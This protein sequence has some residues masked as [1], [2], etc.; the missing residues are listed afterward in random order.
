MKKRA[1]F[2]LLCLAFLLPHPVHADYEASAAAP[3]LTGTVE[4]GSLSIKAADVSLTLRPTYVHML[5]D[6]FPYRDDLQVDSHKP[7]PLEPVVEALV[8]GFV[9]AR[10]PGTKLV[11]VD[12]VEFTDRDSYGAP[13]WDVVKRLGRFEVKIR[14]HRISIKKL[15]GPDLVP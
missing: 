6:A 5:F 8:Q 10:L 14:K 15:S 7:K 3:L 9:L 11:K 12:V 1:P 2:L 4:A 13:N